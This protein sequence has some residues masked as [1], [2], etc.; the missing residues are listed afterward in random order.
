MNFSIEYYIP[1][2]SILLDYIDL[3]I[4][5]FQTGFGFNLLSFVVN[6]DMSQEET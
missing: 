4:K 1:I 2:G 6:E 3:D 5:H